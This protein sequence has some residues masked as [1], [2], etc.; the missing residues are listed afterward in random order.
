MSKKLELAHAHY[1][2]STMS[3]PSRSRPQPPPAA[4]TLSSHS[5]SKAKV[6]HLVA[7]I[8]PYCNYY[9]NPTHKISECNILSQDLFCDYC[10]KEGH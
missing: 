3:P 4:P 5:S 9:G 8:L 6:M 2:A 10:R 1:K 7:P